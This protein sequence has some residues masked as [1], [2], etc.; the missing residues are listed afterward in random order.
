MSPNGREMSR[1]RKQQNKSGE[2]NVANN[3]V[4]TMPEVNEQEESSPTAM[5]TAEK[6]SIQIIAVEHPKVKVIP[7]AIDATFGKNTPSETKG[8]MTYPRMEAEDFDGMLA[9]AA[10]MPIVKRLKVVDE[11]GK[12][13]DTIVKDADGKTLQM[14]PIEKLLEIY[15]AGYDQRARLLVR[16]ELA[17]ELEGPQ[18]QIDTMIKNAIKLMKLPAGREHEA[19]E[20]LRPVLLQMGFTI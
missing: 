2:V 6:K 3:G 12:E 7:D 13:T 5:T 8:K 14:D 1:R 16:N 11:N 19:R 18:R 20:A 17:S 10:A 4:D 9:M 15:N